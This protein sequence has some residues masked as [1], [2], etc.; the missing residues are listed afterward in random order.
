M[1]SPGLLEAVLLC[2]VCVASTWSAR[3]SRKASHGLDFDK[4]GRLSFVQLES[5]YEG[6]S[7][8]GTVVHKELYPVEVGFDMQDMDAA[9]GI[10]MIFDKQSHSMRVEQ[11]IT[12]V[13]GLAWG[14]YDD[15]ID[16]SGWSQL[17]METTGR[18]DVSND[19]RMYAAGYVEGLLTCIRI[20]E[21]YANTYQLLMS[22]ESATHSLAA[23]KDLFRKEIT[24]LKSKANVQQHEFTD[25]PKDNYWKHARYIFYQIWGICDGYNFAAKHF[26]VNTLGLEDVV[27]INSGGELPQLM[28]AYTPSA[29]E[30]RMYAQGS[31]SFLQ[32]DRSSRRTGGPVSTH[33]TPGLASL[34]MS[35]LNSSHLAKDLPGDA[36]DDFHWERRIIESGRCSAYV[37]VAD[38]NTDLLVGHTTWADYSSMTRIFKYYKY[39][40]A[41]AET[42]ASYIAFSSYPG[43]VSSTDDFY[44]TDS[45]LVAMETS[46]EVLTPTAYDAVLDFPT[47]PHLPNFI[48]VMVTNRLAKNAGHW[49]NLFASVNTGTYTSQWMVID[50]TQF[51]PGQPVSDNTL[52]VVEAIPGKVEMKDMSH[53]LRE[54]KYWPS[55]NRPF[56]PT[57]REASG[58][59]AAQLSHGAL[60]SW[61][62]NPRAQIFRR[63]SQYTNSLFDMRSLMSRNRY[64]QSGVVPSEPG[65]EIS[66]RMDLSSQ[67]P[68]PNGGIDAK[69][70]SRCLAAQLQVQAVSSPSH[71]MQ[72]PF[73][74]RTMDHS[75]LWPGWAHA[76]LPDVWDFDFVQMTPTG[77]KKNMFDSSTC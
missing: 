14:H 38:G 65:H 76:G 42:E 1:M 40:L 15:N 11:G 48:H 44:L 68:I 23:V 8:P 25:E 46:L 13:N 2:G 70:T 51:V 32:K 9:K 72:K 56:F 54:H 39:Q 63:E 49:T 75:E 57:I 26:R 24:Y 52:W 59:A 64:P 5:E 73:R 12:P 34:N 66:A 36:L 18:A 20:S 41:G 47:K 69:I 33:V 58:H 4:Q 21:Y 71:G 60:Y 50:Y 61:G 29:I 30:Q 3:T 19:V 74:W 22:K 45:G 10:T 62:G 7:V 43:A 55:F 53:Y 67:M 28:E 31:S 37:R 6:D 77:A 17:H 16:T 27:L 35:G